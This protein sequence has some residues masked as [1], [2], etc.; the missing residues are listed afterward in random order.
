MKD[1]L[2]ENVIAWMNGDN[3][4]FE[5][6]FKLEY[7]KVYA[8]IKANMTGFNDSDIEDVTQDVFIK[9]YEKIHTLEN[10]DAFEGW[11]MRIARNTA[12]NEIERRKKIVL[13]Q[14]ISDE[15]DITQEDLLENSYVEFQPEEQMSRKEIEDNLIDI[16]NTIPPHM[17]LCL[18]MKEYDDMSYQE[19]A[20]ELGIS[21]SSVKNNIFQ[22]K[23]KIR[24]EMEARK[25]YSVAPVTFFFWMYRIYV[26][27]MELG[28]ETKVSVWNCIQ[29]SL[30]MGSG[31]SV[32]GIENGFAAVDSGSLTPNAV[33]S[34]FAGGKAVATSVAASTPAASTEAVVTV[35]AAKAGGLAVGK[36]V[37]VISAVA[38]IGVAGGLGVHYINQQKETEETA[39]LEQAG[40]NLDE[41]ANADEDVDIALEDA[42]DEQEELS[43]QDDEQ[44]EEEAMVSTDNSDSSEVQEGQS[45][46]IEN[47]Y[48][49]EEQPG[50]FSDNEFLTPEAT[51]FY[52]IDGMEKSFTVSDAI[53]AMPLV[54][55]QG[56]DHGYN[57]IRQVGDITGDGVDE[58]VLH[59]L[60]PGNTLCETLGETYV[61]TIDQD[62]KDLTQILFL[63]MED[64][65]KYKEGYVYNI[66]AFVQDGW[67]EFNVAAQKEDFSFAMAVV[68]LV[69]ENGDWVVY[70]TDGRSSYYGDVN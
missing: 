16:L 41:L 56:W 32:E 59:F 65:A 45:T 48:F 30:H 39:T 27:G 23:K 15:E 51:V 55:P 46:K 13:F 58:L 36:I 34:D 4:A 19:I 67:L 38:I 31:A 35:A 9:A 52:T 49:K 63:G 42:M 11:L 57:V 2:R 7:T 64:A 17:S 24:T 29:E 22:C 18:Q 40:D 12:I 14:P 8:R 5:S 70:E 6:I 54:L 66:G 47:V 25:L 26:E 60:N 37:A 43:A 28:Q 21:L 20:D 61:Y 53:S 33:T 50:Y 10:P 1:M 44:K 68:K 3:T 69:Y 62:K